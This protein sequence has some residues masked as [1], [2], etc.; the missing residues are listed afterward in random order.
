MHS[1]RS[2]PGGGSPPGE[3]VVSVD[4]FFVRE[5]TAEGDLVLAFAADGSPVW[6]LDRDSGL[7][8][9]FA[10]TDR[11][12]ARR[13]I[14]EAWPG[15]ATMPITAASYS[16]PHPAREL[17]RR[18]AARPAPPE[19]P[20]D[21]HPVVPWLR[22]L[23][24]R[25]LRLSSAGRLLVASGAIIAAFAL[26]SWLLSPFAVGP[27]PADTTG[28]SSGPPAAGEPCTVRGDTIDDADGALLVC[29]T[30]SRALSSELIWRSTG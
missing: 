2:P 13:V 27:R 3:E 15:F 19:A 22:A 6:A 5:L 9:W 25:F 21:E 8:W 24:D 7:Q 18:S 17:H 1:G 29:T 16:G 12:E 4:L 23:R 14:D 11:A 10:D 26:M 30:S 28:R 20:R